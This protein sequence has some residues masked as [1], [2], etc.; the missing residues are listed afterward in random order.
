MATVSYLAVVA[1]HLAVMGE[2]IPVEDVD[3]AS[4]WT[5]FILV[6]LKIVFIITFVYIS[7]VNLISTTANNEASTDVNSNNTFTV[8]AE[9]RNVNISFIDDAVLWNCRD[10]SETKRYYQ[11][12]YL[13]LIVS[14]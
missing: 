7:V 5:V 9:H 12:L 11:V 6:D 4:K 10:H 14:F 2:G 8:T 3:K 1:A 13:M